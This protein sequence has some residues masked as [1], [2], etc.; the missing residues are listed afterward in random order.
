MGSYVWIVKG[1]IVRRRA[2]A[3]GIPES[4]SIES[5]ITGSANA[6]ASFGQLTPRRFRH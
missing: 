4:F 2:Q 5:W 6:D 1:M 3:A